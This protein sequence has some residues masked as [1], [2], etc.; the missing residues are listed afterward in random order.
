MTDEKKKDFPK[1]SAEDQEQIELLKERARKMGLK[2]HHRIGLKKLKVLVEEGLNPTKP[3]PTPTVEPKEVVEPVVTATAEVTEDIPSI[4]RITTTGRK[5]YGK[6]THIK[7][8]PAEK[9]ARLRKEAN[10]LVRVRVTC[11]NPNKKDWEGEIYTVSNTVVGTIRKYVPFNAENGWHVPQFILTAMREK[12]C[13]IFKTVKGPRGNK[14]RKGSIISELNIEV[15]PP[16]T[17]K[18]IDDLR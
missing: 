8:R 18:E 9:K 3:T 6:D 11:M 10:A 13:Q 12:K 7:E 17:V 16:L 5:I 15:M 1:P 14:I 2:F 4:V